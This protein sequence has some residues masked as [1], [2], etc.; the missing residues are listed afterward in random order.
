[1][2]QPFSI[3]SE[4]Y[5]GGENTSAEAVTLAPNQLQ[6]A[7]NCRLSTMG[8][9]T[10]RPGYQEIS[11]ATFVG[12]GA[13]QGMFETDYGIYFVNNGNIYLTLPDLS[14]AFLIASGLHATARVRFI[15]FLGDIF[16][17]NGEDRPRRITRTETKTAL[18]AATST[19]LDITVGSG[20]RYGTSGTLVVISSLGVDSIT[21]SARTNDQFTITAATVSLAT[22]INSSLIEVSTLSTAPIGSFG[23]VFQNTWI[24]GGIKS[25]TSSE[26]F[27]E[28]YIANS[29]GWTLA[30]PEKFYDFTGSGA[31]YTPIGDKGE[32]TCIKNTKSYLMIGKKDR[33]VYC[34]GFD[35]SDQLILGL[36]TDVYGIAGPDCATNV[37]KQLVVFTG[38]ALKRIGEQEGLNNTVPSLDS[39]FDSAFNKYLKTQLLADQSDAFI[40]F[41]PREE[42]AK[43]WVT[44]L[45]GIKECIVIDNK[46][47]PVTLE[48]RNAWMRDTNKFAKCAVIYNEITYWA[49]Q[50]EPKIYQDEYGY[51]DNG[52]DIVMKVKGAEF[53]LSKPKASKYFQ[54]LYIRGTIFTNASITV[55][56]YFDGALV[57]TFVLG[58]SLITSLMS[59]GSI[60]TVTVGLGSIGGGTENETL[61]GY[62]FE[63]EKLLLKRLDTGRMSVE[64]VCQGQAQIFEIK[65]QQIDG[66]IDEVF[67]KKVKI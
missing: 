18:V 67:I 27:N 31:N 28:A 10:M 64:Y 42:L 62:E 38:S 63:V 35:S 25:G 56:I 59:S 52:L 34:S 45:D 54:T 33:I 13:H 1:M 16:T 4:N 21:Y 5:N 43:L 9:F 32:V 41:N 26:K 55:N 12:S 20:S 11:L 49:A 37:G 60:G 15:E 36:I 7:E 6:K 61:E 53:N 47:N 19:T 58:D 46:L 39:G 29:V 23:A 22:A 30:N 24:M 50:T 57:D 66:L 40:I 44:K 14:D 51:S 17:M 8:G 48:P 2:E 3:P 65:S